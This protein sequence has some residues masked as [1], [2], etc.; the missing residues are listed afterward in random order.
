MT[1]S[2]RTG[3]IPRRFCRYFPMGQRWS[4]PV[5]RLAIPAL[6]ALIGIILSVSQYSRMRTLEEIRLSE[7]LTEAGEQLVRIADDL[8]TVAVQQV[9][10]IRGLYESS[11]EVT[12]DEFDHFVSIMGASQK[13]RMGYAPRVAQA[14]LDHF[15]AEIATAEPG[16]DLHGISSD[17]RDEYWPLVFTNATDDAGYSQGFDFG[18]VPAIRVAISTSISEKRA[19][20]ASVTIPGDDTS[21]DFVIVSAVHKDEGPIGIAVVVLRLDELLAPR[22]DQLLGS[23]ARLELGHSG[24][25]VFRASPNE[26]FGSLNVAGKSMKLLLVVDRIETSSAA[27]VLLILG[28]STSLFIGW[29]IHGRSKR[30]EL[31]KELLAL[32]ETLAEKDRFLASVSHELRTPLTILVGALEFLNGESPALSTEMRGM[33]LEDARVGALELEALVEDY[34]TAARLSTGALTFRRAIVDLD[35]VVARLL[36]GMMPGEK[37]SVKVGKLGHCE[38]DSL[39]IRQI[40]RNVINN[41]KRYATS[42]VEIR[43]AGTEE[44]PAIEILNDGDPISDLVVGR[45]FEPFFS[46]S[47][48]SQP[49]SVGLGLAVSRELARG[50]GGDLTYSYTGGHV[51][52]RL[53]LP[54]INHSTVAATA[55]QSEHL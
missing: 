33:L 28:V 8:Q 35:Q 43:A 44:R 30:R 37:L 6:V 39:R 42:E 24:P 25:S 46:R 11:A 45:M 47:S 22:V 13:S 34:L 41:A 23:N 54:P 32:Q 7:G 15:L 29:L 40:L 10:A 18:T 20:A 53:S 17:P 5:R 36:P 52:F 51:M 55:L 3:L 31:S 21:G 48:P 2:S 49:Q 26:W 9:Q 38:G 14:D 27:S 16:F 50:M 19:V 4:M 1:R 12:R